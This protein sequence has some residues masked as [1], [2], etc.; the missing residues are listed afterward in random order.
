[1]TMN[2]NM[3]FLLSAQN[4]PKLLL[5]LNETITGRAC[6][7]QKLS[8]LK[9]GNRTPGAL[10]KTTLTTAY[11]FVNAPK[12]TPEGGEAGTNVA[13]QPTCNLGN[14]CNSD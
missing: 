3:F 4:K 1:M 8:I 2:W 14:I 7:K 6:P 11:H 12:N 9:P 5:S 13:C 10:T